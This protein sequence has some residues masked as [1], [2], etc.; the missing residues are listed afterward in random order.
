MLLVGDELYAVSDR[1]V[2][3]CVDAKSGEIHW[4]ERLG[5]KYSASPIY[6]GG[7][8]Y[9]LSEEGVGIV[10]KA[11]KTFEEIARNALEE[12]TLASY[13]VIDNALLIRTDEHLHRIESAEER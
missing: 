12:R 7:N 5:G 11:G 13:A 1:G 10:F 9:C 4:Q 2:A 8:I 6:A 3:T